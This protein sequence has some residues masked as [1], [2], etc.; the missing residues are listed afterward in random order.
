MSARSGE[1]SEEVSRDLERAEEYEATIAGGTVLGANR[2]QISTGVIIAARYADKLRRVALVALGKYVPKDVI[3]RDVAELNKEL[4]HEIVEKRKLGKLDL[5]RVTVTLHYD[6]SD[7]KLVFDDVKI[8]VFVDEEKCR[9]PYER[10]V[11][12]LKQKLDELTAENSKLKDTVE[13]IRQVLSS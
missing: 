1:S 13:K 7:K 5:I 4:Y 10:E 9:E 6:E 12:E 3:I 8:S 2:Y 11:D